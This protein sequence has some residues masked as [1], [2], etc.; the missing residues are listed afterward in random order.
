[1]RP[2]PFEVAR[3]END[4]SLVRRQRSRQTRIHPPDPWNLRDCLGHLRRAGGGSLAARRLFALRD[5]I[6]S[7]G[8]KFDVVESVPGP[9]RHQ[10]GQADAR[11]PHCQFQQNIRN[12]AAAGIKVICYNFMPVF[13]WTRTSVATEL[14]DGSLTLSFDADMVKESIRKRASPCPVGTRAIAPK[15]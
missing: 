9:R 8:L 4:L 12:C 2:L 11:S 6:E 10:N 5:R 14:P 13:D 7:V 15:S 1:M 3:N